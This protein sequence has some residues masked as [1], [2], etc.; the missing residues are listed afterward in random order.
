MLYS[1][2]C[3]VVGEA[4]VG[5]GCDSVTVANTP[6]VLASSWIVCLFVCDTAAVFHR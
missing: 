6:D 4:N 5:C 1:L 2:V 3:R